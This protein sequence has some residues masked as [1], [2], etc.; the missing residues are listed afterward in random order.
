MGGT[1]PT[2]RAH[3]I[4]AAAIAQILVHLHYF[5]HLDFSSEARWNLLAL[6][7]AVLIMVLFV[8]GSLWIM[9][10]LNYRMM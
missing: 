5:L 4:F 9:H 7:F 3:N 10:N 2:G 6:I 1:L 8:V